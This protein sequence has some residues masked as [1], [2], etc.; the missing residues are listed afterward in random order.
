MNENKYK[1]IIFFRYIPTVTIK[2]KN[3]MM[4]YAVSFVYLYLNRYLCTI[5]FDV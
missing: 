1:R 2:N 4:I 5:F 3:K